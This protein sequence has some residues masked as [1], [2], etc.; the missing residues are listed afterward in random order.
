MRILYF[1]Y[2]VQFRRRIST[3]RQMPCR[4]TSRCVAAALATVCGLAG[5]CLPRTC[6]I[7]RL[8]TRRFRKRRLTPFSFLRV[9]TA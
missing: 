4:L 5:N 9:L 3:P 2:D 1:T 7:D 6:S 8:I